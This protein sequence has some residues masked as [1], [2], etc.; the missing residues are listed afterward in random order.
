MHGTNKQTLNGRFTKQQM[1]IMD[2][3]VLKWIYKKVYKYKKG[4]KK[5]DYRGIQITYGHV[6][7]KF[8]ISYTQAR[9]C[10][11]RLVA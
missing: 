3:K 5:R 2:Y 4:S 9:Y 11:N 10:L 8:K 7:R 6:S 1:E